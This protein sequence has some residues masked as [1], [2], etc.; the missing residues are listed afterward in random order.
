MIGSGMNQDPFEITAPLAVTLQGFD[1]RM[2]DGNA[3]L[4]W[5]TTM[6]VGTQG[7]NLYRSTRRE[8]GYEPVNDKLIEAAGHVSGGEYTY[9]DKLL[10]GNQTYYYR[11]E[12]VAGNTEPTVFGPFEVR[13]SVVFSLGQNAPNP[14]NPSTT[15]RYSV[16]TRTAVT[17]TIYDVA[18][19]AVK[20]LV[21]EVKN[22][23][24]YT[25]T[26]RG[27]NDR[28]EPVASGVYFYRIIAGKYHDTKKMV[29][30]K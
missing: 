25:V 14:F 5:K 2:D 30:L 28:G 9:R 18:G 29:L 10:V 24:A 8:D 20:T 19:R 13:F 7:Y 17:L 15:I 3:V 11:L 6:E 16:P 22:P 23:N 12:E 21:D 27:T 4:H 26:W 1:A